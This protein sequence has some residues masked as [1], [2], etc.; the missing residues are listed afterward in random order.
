MASVVTKPVTK[1]VT[2]RHMKLIDLTA[3]I[4]VNERCM[5]E[6]YP[7]EFWDTK[8]LTAKQHSFVATVA[9]EIIGYVFC[10]GGVGATASI[11]SLAV[12]DKYR[13]KG[14]GKHLMQ[15]CLNTC[16]GSVTLQVRI[17][18][19][20]ARRLYESLGFATIRE[21]PDYYVNPTE[22]AYEMTTIARILPTMRKI[23]L[24][25]E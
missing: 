15:N 12:N 19:T 4:R 10:E 1:Q 21:I 7:R 2:I 13:G 11:L 22:N 5:V 25:M 23:K 8:F 20:Y 24:I 17:N 14:L 9:T 16:P 6:N 3:V 18:N